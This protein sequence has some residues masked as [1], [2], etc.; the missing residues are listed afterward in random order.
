MIYN[1]NLTN[2]ASS[3]SDYN[4][5]FRLE[6]KAKIQCYIIK[7]KPFFNAAFDVL[8]ELIRKYF[9]LGIK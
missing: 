3:A 7:R 6:E 9:W 4:G 8:M 5:L 1:S 2:L